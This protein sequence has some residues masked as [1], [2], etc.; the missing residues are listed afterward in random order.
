MTKR[1]CRP[2]LL[3]W[4][5]PRPGVVRREIDRVTTLVRDSSG[6]SMG[7]ATFSHECGGNTVVLGAL[8]VPSGLWL[9]AVRGW[10]APF[11]LQLRRVQDFRPISNRGQSMEIYPLT[12]NGLL[13]KYGCIPL[14]G[15]S[16]GSSIFKCIL[17]AEIHARWNYPCG[18]AFHNQ[19]ARREDTRTRRRN[20]A[21]CGKHCVFPF[22]ISCRQCFFSS[23]ETEKHDQHLIRQLPI[24]SWNTSG[25]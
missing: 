7:G 17:A 12:F 11:L 5:K 19:M 20:I 3:S 18:V 23:L 22:F 14:A 13:P 8:K 9:H 6:A 24:C 25:P 1:S 2:S 21:T 4:C 10:I 15:M 16:F